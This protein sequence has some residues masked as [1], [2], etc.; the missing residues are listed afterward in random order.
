MPISAIKSRG[1][2]GW[3]ASSDT[4]GCTS[5]G[6]RREWV[7]AV[8]K[9]GPEGKAYSVPRFGG[10]QPPVMGPRESGLCP[11]DGHAVLI[12]VNHAALT[13]A[14][15]TEDVRRPRE[16]FVFLFEGNQDLQA[17]RVEKGA[18]LR[19][20]GIHG[21][22]F[23]LRQTAPVSLCSI[24][25][26]TSSAIAQFL[27]QA[28][29]TRPKSRTISSSNFCQRNRASP[30]D[31]VLFARSRD[32][33]AHVQT[34]WTVNPRSSSEG[35]AGYR[36]GAVG[37]EP[38]GLNCATMRWLALPAA[39]RSRDAILSNPRPMLASARGAR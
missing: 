7:F 16:A 10:A 35:R 12:V 32:P 19:F 37:P 30:P 23:H 4:H 17:V 34:P 3:L 20:V 38:R 11:S 36:G 21:F 8:E 33:Y 39:P 22:G 5:Q 1:F 13:A 31:A 9:R 29:G 2:V 15:D 25:D 24:G 6:V 28:L 27:P 26:R 18:R 14:S